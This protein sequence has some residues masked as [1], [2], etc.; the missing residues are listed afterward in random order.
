[1]FGGHCGRAN[2]YHYHTALPHLIDVVGAA[3]PIAW[4]LDGLAIYGLNEADGAQ[5]KDLDRVQ[6]P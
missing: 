1:L 6:R 5:A 2:D 3:N 4:A